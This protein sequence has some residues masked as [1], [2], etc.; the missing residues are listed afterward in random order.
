MGFGKIAG[1]FVGGIPGMIVGGAA[2]K[3]GGLKDLL[4]GKKDQGTPDKFFQFD[5]RSRETAR[6]AG[7][8]QRSSLNQYMK[9]SDSVNAMDPQ[10]MA[11]RQMGSMINQAT[12]GAQDARRRARDLVAQ[13]GLGGSAAGL[14]AI[15]NSDQGYNR[16]VQSIRAGRSDLE[17]Q[18][19]AQKLGLIG[20]IG[21]GAGN[22]MTQAGQHN[23]FQQGRTATGK[24]GGGLA[25]LAMAAGGAY[26]GGMAGGPQ[27][28]AAGM[29]MGS[30]MGSLLGN[31]A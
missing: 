11:T 12:G 31:M 8:V 2:E 9:A 15:I 1:G 19:L 25:N 26:L 5:P 30:G 10:A 7:D 27:G 6:L 21:Q 29:Q 28:A 13:R 4:F 16:Q 24:R 20:N 18:A 23:V 17:N 22:I 3:K 14:G